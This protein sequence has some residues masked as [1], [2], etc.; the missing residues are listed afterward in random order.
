MFK[1]CIVLLSFILTSCLAVP[2]METNDQVVKSKYVNITVTYSVKNNS[3][4]TEWV[5]IIYKDVLGDVEVELNMKSG[6]S[7]VKSVNFR[8]DEY[9]RELI[10]IAAHSLHGTF[11]T[12]I[13][14]ND[15]N[16]SIRSGSRPKSSGKEYLSLSQIFIDKETI[17]KYR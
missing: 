4:R 2:V 14:I 7:W 9:D 11:E 16:Q 3:N 15:I 17:D 5:V 10:T 13:L 1:T 6:E 12:I 8:L